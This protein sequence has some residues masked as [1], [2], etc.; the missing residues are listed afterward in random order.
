MS[1][2]HKAHAVAP[3]SIQVAVLSCSDSRTTESD[4]GG[5]LIVELAQGAGMNVIARE[6]VPDDVAAIR[7]WVGRL[8]VE[9]LPHPRPDVVLVTG[10][11]GI[12]GRDGTVEAI[13]GLLEKK[14]PGYGELFRWLSF[15]EVGP[16]A[17]LSRATAGTV[18]HTAIFLMP[19]SPKAVRLAMEKLILPELPHVVSELQRHRTP[20]GH[21]R[22]PA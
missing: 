8:L 9:P 20:E 17:M 21:G 12:S 16:A 10:G 7:R 6:L 18:G 3:G 5:A 2:A 19:G 13:E 14:L 22:Q 1:H 4:V 15:Q 11:T